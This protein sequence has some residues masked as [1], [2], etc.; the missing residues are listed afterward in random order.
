MPH[1]AVWKSA[2]ITDGELYAMTSLEQMKQWS[3]V[4]SL[5]MQLKVSNGIIQLYDCIITLK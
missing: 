4:D 5:A 1:S 2:T 3:S